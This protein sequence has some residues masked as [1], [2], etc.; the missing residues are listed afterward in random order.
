MFTVETRAK[1]VNTTNKQGQPLMRDGVPQ[2]RLGVKFKELGDQWFNIMGPVTDP[3]IGKIQPGDQLTGEINGNFFNLNG[4]VSGGQPPTQ[5]TPN[6]QSYQTQE[7]HKA[8]RPQDFKTDDDKMRSKH[9]CMRGEA[10]QAAASILA[11]GSTPTALFSTADRIMDYIVTGT[12][13]NSDDIP[14]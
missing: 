9:Q 10:V 4:V 12:D 6:P 1:N 13:G 5:S 8:A 7:A 2:L 14:F 3:L 11:E